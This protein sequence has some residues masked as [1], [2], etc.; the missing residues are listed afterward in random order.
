MFTVDLIKM[1]IEGAEEQAILG[2][3]ETIERC[4]P[5]WSIASYHIDSEREL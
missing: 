2:A 5:K 3:R 1:D 4:K